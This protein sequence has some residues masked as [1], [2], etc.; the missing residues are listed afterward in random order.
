MEFEDFFDD[1]EDIFRTY[2]Q[3]VDIHKCGHV[4]IHNCRYAQI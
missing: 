1:F 4:D 2:F 3:C